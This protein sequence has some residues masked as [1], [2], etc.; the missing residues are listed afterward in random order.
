MNAGAFHSCFVN[1]LTKIYI[2]ESVTLFVVDD[3][4]TQKDTISSTYIIQVATYL[5]GE[6]SSTNT[7]NKFLKKA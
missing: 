1:P 3:L 5:K 2:L 6:Q 4:F 7:P